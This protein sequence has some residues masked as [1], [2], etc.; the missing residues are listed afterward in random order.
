MTQINQT[1]FGTPIP[2]GGVVDEQVGWEATVPTGTTFTFAIYGVF[3]HG[4]TIENFV[5]VFGGNYVERTETGPISVSF[6][7]HI[8]TQIPVGVPTGDYD[9]LTMVGYIEGD[10]M[11][12]FD[13]RIDPAITVEVGLGATI[14][15]PPL[16][17]RIG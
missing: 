14:I 4:T 15:N 1:T 11:Y 3:G 8:Q 5:A 7:D 17:T 9:C 10:Q 6:I 16:F 13:F 12:Y 2:E